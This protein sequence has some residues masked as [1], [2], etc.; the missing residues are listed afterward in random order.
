MRPVHHSAL[1]QDLERV[2][3]AVVAG[4][5][6]RPLVR[7]ELTTA[8]GQ[9]LYQVVE[10]LWDERQGMAEAAHA[11]MSSPATAPAAF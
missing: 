2:R 1:I 7:P 6:G 9:R 8:R 5:A 3:A 4:V 10:R 11:P